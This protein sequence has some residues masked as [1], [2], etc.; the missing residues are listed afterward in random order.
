MTR[1]FS[2]GL[3]RPAAFWLLCLGVLLPAGAAQGLSDA[4]KRARVDS[5]Y[6]G[7]KKDF[8]DVEDIEAAQAMALLRSGQAIFVDVRTKQEQE[9][10]MLP[11]AVTEGEF[12]KDPG[13]YSGRS[14][15]G[16]CTI[17]YRSGKLA[18]K[19]KAEG[20]RMLNLKGGLLAWVHAGGKVYDR[21]GETRRIHVYG[22]T[23]DLAPSAYKT[24][25]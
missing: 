19:L 7:Y 11:G 14:L 17:S 24:L 2:S 22:R 6:S 12:L 15:I 5:L 10:S 21:N 16:Y 9:V 3:L 8:P 25:W 18:E 20:I 13:K 23:W 1:C 4:E